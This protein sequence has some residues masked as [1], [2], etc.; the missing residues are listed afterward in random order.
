LII[1]FCSK[2]RSKQSNYHED[3]V[4]MQILFRFELGCGEM[5]NKL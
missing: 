2:S 3:S 1:I 4:L 5:E